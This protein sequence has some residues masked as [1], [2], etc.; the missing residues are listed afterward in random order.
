MISIFKL[1]KAIMFSRKLPAKRSHHPLWQSHVFNHHTVH[2]S[3]KSP[4]EQLGKGKKY[5][6]LPV[7]PIT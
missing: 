6:D 4:Y 1:K 3:Q 7:L 5:S 2:R